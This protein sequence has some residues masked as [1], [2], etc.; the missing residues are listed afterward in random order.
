MTDILSVSE[1][2]QTSEDMNSWLIQDSDLSKS[3]V[4]AQVLE[5][6]NLKPT[7]FRIAKKHSRSVCK[8]QTKF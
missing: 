8:N 6:Y 5:T 7:Y 1:I 4:E 3:A 2:F